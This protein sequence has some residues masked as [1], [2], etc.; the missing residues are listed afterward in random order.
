MTWMMPT[1]AGP[2]SP[3]FELFRYD[4]AFTMRV[5]LGLVSQAA[6]TLGNMAIVCDFQQKYDES[7]ALYDR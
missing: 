2:T 1:P 7:V 5:E 6:D 4:E 3:D